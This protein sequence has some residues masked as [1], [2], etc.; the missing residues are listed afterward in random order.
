MFSIPSQPLGK[1]EATPLGPAENVIEADPGLVELNGFGSNLIL[2]PVAHRFYLLPS[3]L[4]R[5][6]SDEQTTYRCPYGFLHIDVLTETHYY[7]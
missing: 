4:G 2:V 5:S 7:T 3:G 6:L 1:P